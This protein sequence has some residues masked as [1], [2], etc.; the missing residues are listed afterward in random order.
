MGYGGHGCNY[1]KPYFRYFMN[2]Y[3]GLCWFEFDGVFLV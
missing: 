2:V 3:D 1:I